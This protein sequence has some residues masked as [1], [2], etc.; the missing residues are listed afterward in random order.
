MSFLLER[1]DHD[2]GHAAASPA[3]LMK[4]RILKPHMTRTTRYFKVTQRDRAALVGP[5]VHVRRSA[6]TGPYAYY[7]HITLFLR[8]NVP[9]APVR[10]V[11]YKTA[12]RR[13][14]RLTQRARAAQPRAGRRGATLLLEI[15]VHRR[16]GSRDKG[17]GWGLPA[18]KKGA[19]FEPDP[20][21]H[22]L[23]FARAWRLRIAEE[24]IMMGVV[25]D[26]RGLVGPP[27]CLE[28]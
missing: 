10:R 27:L 23:L 19:G 21:S 25:N 26:L 9:A 20:G 11:H 1:G 24:N 22:S 15:G 2:F 12:L 14:S 3:L 18:S 17:H 13:A 4:W 7:G 16:S 6:G 5:V 28:D 8:A